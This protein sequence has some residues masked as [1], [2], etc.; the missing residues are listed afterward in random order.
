[1]ASV[2]AAFSPEMTAFTA[3][4]AHTAAVTEEASPS[5]P[6]VRFTE[7]DVNIKNA[8]KRILNQK[9]SSISALKKGI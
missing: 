9:P 2:A 7:F 5:I 3:K 1:M 6:S 4:N 8:M